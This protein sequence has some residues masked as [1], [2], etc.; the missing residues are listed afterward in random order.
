MPKKKIMRKA[1]EIYGSSAQIDMVIEEMSELTKALLKYR[2]AI[3][4]PAAYDYEKIKSNIAE[5]IADVEIMLAQ[6]KMIFECS[7]EVENFKSI[8]L[9]RLQNRLETEK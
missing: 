6:C 5:E 7:A 4:S 9:L 3:K 1:L 2:R 8:K